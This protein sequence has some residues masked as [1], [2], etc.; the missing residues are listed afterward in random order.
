MNAK[1]RAELLFASYAPVLFVSVVNK[2]RLNE[3]IN[4]A[5]RIADAREF[6]ITTGKLNSIIEDA[7]MNASASFGQGKKT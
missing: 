6:R 5:S 1:I 2:Q 3:I 4:T 7:V